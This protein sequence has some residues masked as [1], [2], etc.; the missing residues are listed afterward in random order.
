[1]EDFTEV[2]KLEGLGFLAVYDGHGGKDVAN[3]PKRIYGH[4]LRAVMDL[5]VMTLSKFP[6]L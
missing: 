3:S 6:K 2:T 5:K 4:Q 1:M